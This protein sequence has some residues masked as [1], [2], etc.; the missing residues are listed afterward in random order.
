LP[1]GGAAP[2]PPASAKA[3]E[4]QPAAGRLPSAEELCGRLSRDPAFLKLVAI[5]AVVYDKFP[6]R[7]KAAVEELF[8]K[9]WA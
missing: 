9:L 1:A 5:Y 2:A 3:V 6:E 7:A 8:E 4:P